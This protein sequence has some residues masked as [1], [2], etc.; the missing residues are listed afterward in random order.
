MVDRPIRQLRLIRQ[1][2]LLSCS[3]R[4]SFRASDT[5][6][7]VERQVAASRTVAESLRRGPRPKRPGSFAALVYESRLVMA[8]ATIAWLEAE[9]ERRRAGSA[10]PHSATAPPRSTVV[11]RD[12]PA[13]RYSTVE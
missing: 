9:R 10:G 12:R 3:S 8:H 7:L 11:T 4:D 5:S 6:V 13:R 2:F 1:D